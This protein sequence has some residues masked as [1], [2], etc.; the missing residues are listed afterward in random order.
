MI[1]L[2]A[3]KRQL[4]ILLLKQRRHAQEQPKYGDLFN[5]KEYLDVPAK[6][7][8]IVEDNRALKDK[9]RRLKT[10]CVHW[11]R[12]NSELSAQNQLMQTQVK[13]AKQQLAKCSITVEEVQQIQVCL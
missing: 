11:H 1:A 8:A 7:R 9:S 3:E 2:A 4:E 5:G 6:L 12:R 10:E 13:Q